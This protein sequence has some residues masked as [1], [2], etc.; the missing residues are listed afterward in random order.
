[1]GEL[2]YENFNAAAANI[3]ISGINIHPGTAKDKMLNSILI[4][5]EFNSMLPGN[6]IPACTQGYEGFYHLGRFVGSVEKDNDA[7]HHK[8]LL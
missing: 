7:L 8:G 6:E 2:E 5:A 1:M 3:T 4:A